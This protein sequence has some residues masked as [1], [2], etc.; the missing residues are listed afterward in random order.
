[1][2]CA[3][4]A[5]EFQTPTKLTSFTFTPP[6]YHSL[7]THS[8]PGITLI[9]APFSPPAA[10]SQPDYCNI[11]VLT[12]TLYAFESGYTHMKIKQ[13]VFACHTHTHTHLYTLWWQ[14]L[15][16]GGSDELIFSPNRP[17]LLRGTSLCSAA[18]AAH[19]FTA[20]DLK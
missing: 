9:T 15:P 14:A 1:L 16:E 6:P 8:R 13:N 2:R 11:N 18:D 7:L 10:A 4:E 12:Y 19:S 20:A 5:C 3:F 17:G